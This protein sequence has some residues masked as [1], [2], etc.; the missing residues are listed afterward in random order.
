MREAGRDPELAV[1]DVVELEADPVPEGRAGA[2]HVGRDVENP[3]ARHPH[4]LALRVRIALQVQAAQDAFGRAR[5]VV[6]DEGHGRADGGVECLL[7]EALEKEAARVAEHLRLDD[8][9]AGQG[10]RGHLHQNT[11]LLAICSRYWP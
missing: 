8:Q 4:Q 6:L 10:G 2:A 7:V 11:W 1:A 5:L 9:H 3:A